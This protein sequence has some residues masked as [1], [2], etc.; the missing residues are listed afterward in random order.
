MTWR[1]KLGC[2]PNSGRTSKSSSLRFKPAA[3][4]WKTQFDV[5]SPPLHIC[6]LHFCN[7]L[8]PI[9]NGQT[10]PQRE[11]RYNL[12]CKTS[13]IKLNIKNLL[14]TEMRQILQTP[15][16]PSIL[17]S[18]PP[19]NHSSLRFSILAQDKRCFIVWKK[20]PHKATCLPRHPYHHKHCTWKTQQSP[21]LEW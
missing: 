16:S 18:N 10:Q 17:A 4:Q 6:T 8:Q 2:R 15:S 20:L 5:K 9:G 21:Q 11:I 1:Q 19:E 14:Y 12:H 7:F 13:P 3:A